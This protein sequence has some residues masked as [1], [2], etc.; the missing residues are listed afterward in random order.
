MFKLVSLSLLLFLAN[1]QAQTLPG[2]N[3]NRAT[4]SANDHPQAAARDATAKS[5][6]K[7][8]YRAGEEYGNAGLFLQ[9]AESFKRAIDLR[10]DYAEAHLGLG[11]AYL[12]LQRWDDALQSLEM[13]V[14]L[15]PKDKQA[16]ALLAEAK[17][18]KQQA[19]G[20]KGSE[21]PQAVGIKIAMTDSTREVAP[22]AK[23]AT[24][25][26]A[27][28]SVYRVGAGDVI[29]IRVG[30]KPSGDSTL[31]SI[32]S[33]GLL[34]HPNLLKPLPVAGLTV[35]EIRDALSKD[36]KRQALADNPQVSVA[37]R[38]YQ[39]HTILVSG[40]VKDPGTKILRREAIPLY[41]VVADA[42]PLPEA[43]R[44]SVVHADSAEISI[45]ELT[46]A[47]QMKTL[48]HRGDV[49]TIQANPAQFFYVSGDVKAPGEKPFRRGLKLTQAIIAAGGFSEE[50]KYARIAH[51]NGKGFLSVKVYKLKDIDSGKSP[52]P[53]VQPGDRITISH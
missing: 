26:M 11:H 19:L 7:R 23:V 48:V 35:D 10:P 21:S 8:L 4:D 38:D 27:L 50:P 40:L 9:A 17:L 39:S 34:E 31:F 2:R 42:Q 1:V 49:I 28:T 16:Q 6:A 37:V 29:D 14:K 33:A 5:Q 52:D 44:V 22:S 15:K 36:L 41:V 47:E 3:V 43:G 12:D 51:D 45:V 20:G 25:E 18:A 30:D 46:E 53:S 13:A 24:N 32:T